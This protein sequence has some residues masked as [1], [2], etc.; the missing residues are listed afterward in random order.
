MAER[1]ISILIADD[2]TLVRNTLAEWLKSHSGFNVISEV[3]NADD[4][5]VEAS[6]LKPDIAVLDIDMPG[7][8]AFRA[9]SMIKKSSPNTKILILSAFYHDHYIE[10]ALSVGAM[11]YV[12]KGDTS[13]TV[14]EAIKKISEG[15]AY[16]SPTIQSRIVIDERG[17]RLVPSARTKLSQITAR[18]LEVLR[19]LAHGLSKK[20]IAQELNIS[21]GTI[22]NHVAN[23]MK[24]LGIHDRVELTRFAIREGLIQL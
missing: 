8:F 5:V 17:A 14:A 15:E 13:E 7:I 4:A 18:E 3:D 6:K 20:E 24:K 19:H 12:T 10:E 16:F 11:G 22:N 9:A 21:L 23:L 2:H 1:Q